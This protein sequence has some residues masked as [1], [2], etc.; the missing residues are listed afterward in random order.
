MLPILIALAGCGSPCGDGVPCVVDGG[1]YLAFPP[2]GARGPVPLVLAMHGAGSEA[3][4][5]ASSRHVQAA[6]D[7]GV[8]LV[9]PEGEDG[10]WQVVPGFSFSDDPRDDIA[11]LDAVR[12]DALDRF[13][14]DPDRT[15]ST[16]F[17]IGAS[18][19]LL[20]ACDA[21]EA[22]TVFYPTGGS[23]WEPQP[24]DC[25]SPV[26]PVRHVHGEADETWPVEGRSFGAAQQGSVDDEMALWTNVH[27]CDPGATEVHEDGP[28]TC[29]R[30]T[31][32]RT[33]Q[34]VEDCR[35]DGGHQ[36]PDDWIGAMVAFAERTW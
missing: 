21:P 35:H 26:R 8:L 19:S 32:C 5:I 36:R 23:F 14:A 20:I 25:G 18:M 7:A 29:T 2:P 10:G 33:G 28:L 24:A 15:I 27:G 1:Q 16:G 13:G 34:P 6:N 11:W 9:A 3:A 31:D 4:S 17:S 30:W 22:W 12:T